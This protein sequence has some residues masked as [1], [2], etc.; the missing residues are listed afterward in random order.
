MGVKSFHCNN[1]RI[2]YVIP[3]A[4]KSFNGFS[5]SIKDWKKKSVLLVLSFTECLFEKFLVQLM[6]SWKIIVALSGR[7]R[8]E[9]N[10]CGVSSQKLLQS[11]WGTCLPSNSFFFQCSDITYG[12][13]SYFRSLSQLQIWCTSF[14]QRSFTTSRPKSQPLWM[15]M[16]L[17]RQSMVKD[18]VSKPECSLPVLI[19]S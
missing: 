15:S 5:E 18:Q 3:Q 14:H 7:R 9:W 19:S 12:A 4:S 17:L 11:F 13:T 6:F 16:V 2:I 10:S 1:N 8:E